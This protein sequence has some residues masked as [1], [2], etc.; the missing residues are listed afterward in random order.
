MCK[1]GNEMG[2]VTHMKECKTVSKQKIFLPR[3]LNILWP[4]NV[5]YVNCNIARYNLQMAP[6]IKGNM[7]MHILSLLVKICKHIFD[8]A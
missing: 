8:A 5:Y 7:Y 3:E 4:N 1:F 2:L 6:Y